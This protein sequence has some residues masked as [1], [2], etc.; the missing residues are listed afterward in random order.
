MTQQMYTNVPAPESLLTFINLNASCVNLVPKSRSLALKKATHMKQL[1][2]SSTLVLIFLTGYSQQ[3]EGKITYQRTVQM[4][5]T[6]SDHPGG[7]RELPRNRTDKFELNFANGKM[8]WKQAEEE[9]EDDNGSQGGGMMIRVMG[10][11]VDDAI[12]CDFDQARR[13]EA[14]EFFEK[15]FIITD[16]IRHANWK[17]SDETKTI[18]N[19]LCRKATSQRYGKR[20]MMK[21]DNGKMERQEVNDTATVVA[22][23][24]TDIPVAVGPEMQG[25]LPGAILEMDLN[26]GRMHYTALE[27][28]PKADVAAI[29]E[30]TKGKKVT[31]AEFAT[32]RNK[33]MDEMERNNQGGNMRIRIN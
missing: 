21:M 16:S 4:Q 1:L 30:P 14:R 24:T 33:L 11:G 2:A 18:L 8:I 27:I 29:K 12:F 5:I 13:V 20:M 25:Q 28:L 31:P 19:H 15:K 3:K 9:M 32:E 23:F 22:W 7:E 6:I 10:G 17:I 26:E